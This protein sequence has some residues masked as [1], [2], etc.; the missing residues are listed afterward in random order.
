MKITQ[1][2]L[3][4]NHQTNE[5][6]ADMSGFRLWFR[7]PSDY[8][9][10]TAGDPFLAAGFFPS[11]MTGRVLEIENKVTISSRL[12]DGITRLQ[13]VF[14]FWNPTL[15][16][17]KIAGNL[18]KS[19]N[20]NTGVASFF[21]GGIDGL[22][23]L[24]KNKEEITH[25]VYINGFDFEMLPDEFERATERNR[26][27]ISEF[28]KKLIP[29]ETN[30]F[31]FMKH[32]KIDRPLNHGSC[33]ASIA[34]LLGFSKIYIPASDTYKRPSPWGSHPA[35]DHLWSTEGVQIIHDGAEMTRMDKIDQLIV[36]QDLI[37]KLIVCWFKPNENCCT[38]EKCL[39]TMIAL[40][41]FGVQSKAF[42]KQLQSKDILNIEFDGEIDIE[43][44]SDLMVFS[45]KKEK[46]GVAI[47]LQA[48]IWKNKIRFLIIRF[49]KRFLGGIV[50]GLYSMVR[51]GKWLTHSESESGFTGL[52]PK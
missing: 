37:D 38:C 44:F 50:K 40:E 27:L 4:S 2:T 29:V 46:L 17:F 30:F 13:E 19:L 41:I 26:K 6:S 3:T 14:H 15:C 51:Y 21:S 18:D 35:I 11:M 28:G 12:A 43:Y 8:R 36:K 23:T 39:R 42:P 47:L 22:S 7:V 25:L 16:K 9:I 32:H 10:S 49:D 5:I 20:C 48:A 34:L 24:M 31:S 52:L 45:S 1:I 33:L